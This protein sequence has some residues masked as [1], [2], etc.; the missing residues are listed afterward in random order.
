M[1]KILKIIEKIK[2]HNKKKAPNSNSEKGGNN[3]PSTL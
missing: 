3:I 1:A 2:H